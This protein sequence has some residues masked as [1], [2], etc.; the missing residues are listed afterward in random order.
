MFFVKAKFAPI[1]QADT[2]ATPE[3]KARFERREQAFDFAA[4]ALEDGATSVTIRPE[5]PKCN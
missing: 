3:R 2:I 5:Q 4:Q 1:N